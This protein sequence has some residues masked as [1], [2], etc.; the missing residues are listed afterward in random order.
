MR[1]RLKLKKV[2]LF[3]MPRIRATFYKWKHDVEME[4][5]RLS[6]EEDGETALERHEARMELHNL[7]EFMAKEGY[8]KDLA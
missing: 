2:S 4:K 8:P 6:A 3:L 7:K 1:R 5:T